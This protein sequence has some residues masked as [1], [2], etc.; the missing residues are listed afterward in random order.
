MLSDR[1]ALGAASMRVAKV[2]W[3]RGEGNCLL[4]EFVVRPP[5]L[6]AVSLSPCDLLDLKNL[7][8]GSNVRGNLLTITMLIFAPHTVLYHPTPSSSWLHGFYCQKALADS[9]LRRL[10]NSWRLFGRLGV[11]TRPGRCS[12]CMSSFCLIGC[13][14]G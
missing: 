14:S 9:W 2:S 10:A 1:L 11:V 5:Q 6:F 7:A 12:D 8:R 13:Y 3:C 4:C